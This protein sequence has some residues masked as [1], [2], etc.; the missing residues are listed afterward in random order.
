MSKKTGTTVVDFEEVRAKKL[1]EKRRKTERI[2]FKH[3]LGVY[4]VSEQEQLREIEL[5]DVSEEGL[6]FQIPIRQGGTLPIEMREVNLRL[7]FSQDTYIPLRLKVQNS[8]HY[9]DG[10]GQYARFGC[11]VDNTLQSYSA[12]QQFVRFLKCY[13]EHAHQD[14]GKTTIFYL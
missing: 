1:D 3:L 7:Y 10:T 14:T 6:S 8:K 13:A 11:S 2:I 4:A 9:V 5:I 12:Y